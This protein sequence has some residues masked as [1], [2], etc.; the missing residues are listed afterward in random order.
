VPKDHNFPAGH[1]NLYTSPH[2]PGTLLAKDH[3]GRLYRSQD[4]GRSW[5]YVDVPGV[6]LGV[7]PRS[8]ILYRAD[9]YQIRRSTDGG[10]TWSSIAHEL[11][12][13]Q[14]CPYQVFVHPRDA[15][16][17][18]WHTG[19]DLYES[20]DAGHT[21]RQLQDAPD[22]NWGSLWFALD[23]RRVYGV[24]KEG[25]TFVSEDSGETWQQRTD[26]IGMPHYAAAT[27]HPN[28]DDTFLVAIPGHGIHKTKDGG[29]TWAMH[30]TG[31]TN[32]YLNAL[33]FDPNTPT[34]VYAT[35]D[36]GA[37]ISMNGGDRWW[38]IKQGLGPNPTTYTILADPIYPA[39]VYVTTPDGV[40]R[41]SEVPG[42][43][44]PR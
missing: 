41:L 29:R 21:W 40:F 11:G 44:D 39:R 34:T 10:G 7:D 17:L 9:S 6:G 30:S 26:S 13:P 8:G 2:E 42:R 24:T 25:T 32:L 37:F 1:V 15:E 31:L 4:E 18:Y 22:L 3:L 35:S 20:R 27:L 38:P 33:A 14:N 19:T 36:S 28:D 16:W 12:C 43:H 5:S 23:G